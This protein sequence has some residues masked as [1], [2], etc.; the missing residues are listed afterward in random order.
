MTVEFGQDGRKQKI[1]LRAIDAVYVGAA[2]R[3]AGHG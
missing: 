1:L 3:F 2:M